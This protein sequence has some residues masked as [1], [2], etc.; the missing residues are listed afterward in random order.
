MNRLRR[1]LVT[2]L[3]GAFSVQA[4]GLNLTMPINAC[5]NY[6]PRLISFFDSC[7]E[8]SAIT[9]RNGCTKTKGVCPAC[10]T[11]PGDHLQ[12]WLPDYFVEVTPHI[13]RSVF[14]ENAAGSALNLHLK[15]AMAWWNKDAPSSAEQFPNKK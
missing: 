4:S 11:Y 14:A 9:G 8:F 1:Y 15:A 5:T 2:I 6:K 7:A 10:V 13:G 3:S 12:M